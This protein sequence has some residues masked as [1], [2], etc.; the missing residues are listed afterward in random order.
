MFSIAIV[1]DWRKKYG[2]DEL[3]PLDVRFTIERKSYYIGTG[4]RVLSKHW[5]GAVVSR[6]DADALNN[7]LGIIVR[8]VNEK[9]NEFIEQRKPIDVDAIKEYIFEG[10]VAG[11]GNKSQRMLEWFVEQVPF[12][13]M[14]DSTRKRY[15]LLC[16][17]L[18][19]YGKLTAWS[20]LSVEAIYEWD[21]W[22]HERVKA[23]V[24][25]GED[26]RKG[27]DA[28]IYNYHKGLKALLHRAVDFG[29][30]ES[31][32]YERLKGKFSRGDEE[33][34]EFLNEEQMQ[35]ILNIRPVTGSQ[36]ETVRDLFVFQMFTGL[37]Y[38]DMQAFD[39][40]QYKQVVVD[41]IDGQKTKQW[42]ANGKRIKTGVPY[43]SV[44][45]PPVVDVLERHGMRVPQM[46][47]QKY[48][49]LLKTM[50]M[51]IGIEGLHSHLARHTFATYMLSKDVKVQNL[52]RMMGH[53][54]ILQTMK[55]AKVLAK[56]VYDEF[57]RVGSKLKK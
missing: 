10:T 32:P 43:V 42:V 34:I 7:R 50:G 47:N 8:R 26:E 25:N 3:A 29:L 48:N 27:C 18:K 1:R 37:A 19:E 6:P 33:N 22:L 55:Y 24:K 15:W 41:G 45:L 39:I 57:E 31:S 14:K 20:D 4:V 17:R 13:K 54:N 36:M 30:I 53:T 11:N 56:D 23:Q 40:K 12:L 9:V 5:A 46:P 35:I 38:S 2:E 49:A 16:D 21:S 52:M 28:T 44:L 51:V